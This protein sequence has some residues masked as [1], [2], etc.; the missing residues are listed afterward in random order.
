MKLM[1]EPSQLE[2]LGTS[3]HTANKLELNTSIL[4]CPVKINTIIYITLSES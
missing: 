4:K 1:N 2:L 3:S